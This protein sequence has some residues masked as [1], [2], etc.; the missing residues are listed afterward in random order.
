[1]TPRVPDRKSEERL[2]ELRRQAE[3]TGKVA[4]RGVRPPGSP[5]PQATPENGYYGLPLLKEPPWTWEIPLYFFVGGAAGAAS[6]IAAAAQLRRRNGKLVRDARLL[7]VAGA[8]ASAPLLISDLGRPA[9]FLNMLRVFKPQSPMSVGAWL[10]SAFSAA[11][12]AALA[13]DMAARSVRRA[14]PL[15]IAGD[16]AGATAALLGAGMATY[17]GVLIGATTVPVWA[18]NLRT[19]PGHFAASGAGSAVS[20]LELVGH[21]DQALNRIGIAEAV[22]ETGVGA[23]F[24]LEK[25]RTF[26]PLRH[27]ASGTVTRIG[28]VLS[29]PIPLALRIFGRTSRALRNAAAISTIVGSLITRYAWMKAGREST[30][31]ASL[32]LQLTPRQRAADGGVRE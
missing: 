24:E 2:D 32:P 8:V 23:K 6:V 9:R 3:V 12:S 20:I 7:A 27:G 22:V 18:K 13:A 11:A 15:R 21:H 31:E 16:L 19:L 14:T 30:R 10:L 5:F 29:G 25:D 28:G 4:M 1:M 17:T 26:D